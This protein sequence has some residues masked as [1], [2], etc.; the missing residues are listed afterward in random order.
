M[1]A[2]LKVLLV[3]LIGGM[4][5][6][7]ASP[8][9]PDPDV[10]N[11]VVV[12]KPVTA[13]NPWGE[14]RPQP[15]FRDDGPRDWPG[16]GYRVT[17]AD[18]P[19]PWMVRAERHGSSA[20][21]VYKQRLD[22]GRLRVLTRRLSEDEWACVVHVA[23]KWFWAA[24]ELTRYACIGGWDDGWSGGRYRQGNNFGKSLNWTLACLTHDPELLEQYH[25]RFPE[26]AGCPL[27]PGTCTSRHCKQR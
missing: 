4:L 18:G 14:P 7:F 19:R 9:P 12:R 1:A 22:G 21:L 27:P 5:F 26:T 6:A 2:N 25:P 20:F 24:D 10:V 16:E 11:E 8:P 15:D 3:V 23:D 17:H 13:R